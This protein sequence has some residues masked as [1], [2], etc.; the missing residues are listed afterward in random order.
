MGAT[1]GRRADFIVGL[2]DWIDILVE[3]KGSDGNLTGTRGA[4]EQVENT[5]EVWKLDG[6]RYPRIA[7]AIIYGRITVKKKLPGRVPRAS[8]ERSAL[9][10]RFLERH[11]TILLIRE[12]GEKQFSINDFLRKSDA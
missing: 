11:E 8:A 9:E 1:P 5:M 10:A 4:Y 12:N 3:L 2:W 7:A 6:L